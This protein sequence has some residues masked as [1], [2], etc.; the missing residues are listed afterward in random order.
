[1]REHLTTTNR[2]KLVAALQGWTETLADIDNEIS[3]REKMPSMS[4]TEKMA[5]LAEAKQRTTQVIAALRWRIAK[6]AG[7]A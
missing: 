4:S 2:D 3:Q 7:T 6:H 1:M 5:A